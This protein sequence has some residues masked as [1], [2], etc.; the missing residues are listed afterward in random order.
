MTMYTILRETKASEGAFSVVGEAE[1]SS[2][3]GAIRAFA[4]K[5][6]GSGGTF[7]AIPSRSW[8]PVTVELE[9]RVKIG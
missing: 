2:A 4:A 5:D 1:A 8:Q 3:P 7:V 6:G 9:T